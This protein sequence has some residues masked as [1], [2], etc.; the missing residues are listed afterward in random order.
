MLP[1]LS[2]YRILNKLGAGGMGEVYLAEDTRLHRRVAL[3]FLPTQFTT[4][5]TRVRRFEKEARAA[6]ALNH[7]NIL[8]IHEIG[9]AD[10]AHFIATEFVEGTTLRQRLSLAPL[11]L[12][13]ALDVA[14]QVAAALQA[15]HAIGVVHRDI[16]T[17]KLMLRHDGYVKV[18][19]FGLAKFVEIA[20][21]E[22]SLPTQA[23][24]QTEPGLAMGTTPYMSPEQTRG[25]KVDARTDIWSLGV[26]LYETLTGHLP[27][28]GE[29][30]SDILAAILKSE[31]TPLD[32]YAPHAPVELRRIISRM[33]AKD[34]DQRYQNAS[35]LL[36]DL[37]ALKR[38]QETT[39]SQG[40]PLPTDYTTAVHEA[41]TIIDQNTTA[42]DLQ[43][44]TR[45]QTD[46]P[47][48][49]VAAPRWWWIAA[50]LVVLLV[51]ALLIFRWGPRSEEMNANLLSQLSTAQIT[52]WKSDLGEDLFN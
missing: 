45:P 20:T 10:G 13:E 3:K 23:A 6:S 17:E 27:F 18:L 41:V 44:A 50:L 15:A 48:T 21:T 51:A 22:D 4:D 7:P 5:A 14:I 43:P 39:P 49:R 35:E 24:T 33:L 38:T 25:L 37:R 1:A 46:A 9:E 29:T 47:Q 12:I 32:T 52:S 30:R 28:T 8:T 11:G 36:V 42:P 34:C 40:D 19:D 26:V 16:K 2:R 31:P